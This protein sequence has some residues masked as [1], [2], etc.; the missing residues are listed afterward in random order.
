MV[1]GNLAARKRDRIRE[2]VGMRDCALL[3]LSPYSPIFNPIE[4]TFAKVKALLRRAGPRPLEALAEAMGPTLGAASRGAHGF[5]E[6][7]A[8]AEWINCCDGHR[9]VG[10]S[11]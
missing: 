6:H 7:S 9:R 8:T 3:F 2:L 10:A 11:S 5:F 1:L 4:E